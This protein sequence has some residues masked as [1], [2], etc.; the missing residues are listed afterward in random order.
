MYFRPICLFRYVVE[1]AICDAT[2]CSKTCCWT[3]PNIYL[4]S[5]ASLSLALLYSLIYIYLCYI[6][7]TLRALVIPFQRA[8]YTIIQARAMIAE[9]NF[10]FKYGIYLTVQCSYTIRIFS[11]NVKSLMMHNVIFQID[12]QIFGKTHQIAPTGFHRSL[13]L[14]RSA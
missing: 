7:Q 3:H 13:R 10:S 2:F 14:T 9:N 5:T 11:V 12:L 4:S 8:K 1:S 6:Q